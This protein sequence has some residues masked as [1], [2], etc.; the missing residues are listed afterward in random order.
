MLSSSSLSNLF[1]NQ[2]FF[3]LKFH[4]IVQL[5]CSIQNSPNPK[6]KDSITELKIPFLPIKS[7]KRVVLVRHGQ[8]TWNEQGRIQGSSNFSVL[9]QKGE[10]QAEISRQMLLNDSFDICFAS[11]LARS[12]R[13][14]EVIWNTREEAIIDDYDLRE[15]DLYSFQGLLKQ[16]GKD[17]F[18]EAYLEWQRDAPNFSIDGHYPVRELW[19]RARNCWNKILDHD[20]ISVLVVAHNAVNQAL[21]CT[22]IGLSTEYFRILVQSNCGV[23]VLD[24]A[25][26]AEG[27]PPRVRLNRVNQT[28]YSPITAPSS[29][30]RKSTKRIILAC[31]GPTLR[32]IEEIRAT[33]KNGPMNMLG[34]IQSQKTAELLLDSKVNT[35]IYSTQTAS[36]ETAMTISKVQESADCL[37]ADCVPRYVDMKTLPDLEVESILWQ[38]KQG[39]LEVS[40]FV[41]GWLNEFDDGV[42]PE[43]WD[44]SGKVW[45][46]LLEEFSDKSEEEE[47]VVVVGHA[48]V[49]MALIGHCLNLTEEWMGSFHL[50]SGSISVIDFPDGPTGRG[51]IRCTNYTAHLG[52]WAV[53]VTS[54]TV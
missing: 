48:A 13:T 53:P 23:T 54:S 6:Q 5:C 9:T 52:R 36:F 50:D 47:N 10:T 21:I 11:P 24:F 28:P 14:A 22:A 38:S 35:I 1:T 17:K 12:R 49:N 29:D 43:I 42:I 3:P 15:I 39:A 27:G 2:T 34:I 4:P 19:S 40:E 8:S 33:P 20:G 7:P 51:I 46:A 37:G 44:R 26:Q 30:G 45:K 25:P 16:E 41:P 31:H 18:G 32:S